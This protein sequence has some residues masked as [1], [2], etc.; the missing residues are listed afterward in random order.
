MDIR[1]NF[2]NNSN[3]T[4]NT[5]VLFYSENLLPPQ[6]GPAAA[7][8]VIRNCGPGSNHPFT[9]PAASQIGYLDS[10]GNYTPRLPAEAG[11]SFAATFTNAGDTIRM[12][13]PASNPQAIELI[14]TLPSGAITA[15]IY[16]DSRLYMGGAVIHP[17]ARVEFVLEP[18][19]WIGTFS[20]VTSADSPVSM[21]IAQDNSEIS[22]LGIASADIVMT[23]SGPGDESSPFQFTLQNIVM[24]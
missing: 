20:Q 2:I 13:G 21:S 18:R 24:A 22:L 8:K 7:W 3:D 23:G 10:D 1:L 17:G 4:H 12:T 9:Y 14:N 16:K 11:Q 19:L 15:Q 5:Q 6:A